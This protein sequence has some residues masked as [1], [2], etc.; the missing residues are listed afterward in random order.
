MSAARFRVARAPGPLRGEATVPGDKSIGHRAVIFAALAA[1]RSRLAGLSGGEDNRRT[2]DAFRALGIAIEDAGPGAL[3]V[4]G[5]GTGGLRAPAGALDCG[6]SGTTMRLLCGVLAPRPFAS[7]LAG[8]EYLHARPMGRVAAP[9]AAMGARIEG[10]PGKRPGEI[11]PPLAI[12][13]AARAVALR[14]VDW[15]S[16]IASAPVQSAVILA[17]L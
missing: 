9:L 14:G 17:A 6:N 5:A 4:D 8:D 13:A 3:F 12:N 7:T 11:Y 1:G 16:P 10:H 2:V 15:R